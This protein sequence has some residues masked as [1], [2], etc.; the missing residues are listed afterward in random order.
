MPFTINTENDRL[1][2]AICKNGVHSF[3][4]F[5]VYDNYQVSHVLCRVGKIF[6]ISENGEGYEC[7]VRSNS[8]AKALFSSHKGKLHDEGT[9]RKKKG[10]QPVSYQAYEISFAQYCEFVQFLESIQT[11]DNLFKCYKPSRRQGNT[12]NLVLTSKPIY[13][14]PVNRNRLQNGIDEI[15]INNTCRHTARELLTKV[16][17]APVSPSV[18]SLFFNELPYYTRLDFGKPSKDVPFYV[19][20]VTPYAYPSLGYE[21]RKIAEK[22]YL[23][24]EELVYLEPESSYTRIKFNALEHLYYQITGPQKDVSLNELLIGIQVWRDKNKRDLG[25]LRKTYFWDAFFVRKSAT[26]ILI[27]EVESD[28]QRACLR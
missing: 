1:F 7:L 12:I 27:D 16:Q 3:L 11:R 2:I 21:K 26:M 20:P 22:L 18:S 23:R 4:M 24:M 19:L 9:F 17:K 25:M 6:D 13:N 5:G 10:E 15:G 28:L 8:V 14:Q